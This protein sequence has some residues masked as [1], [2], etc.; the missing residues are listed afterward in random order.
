MNID[1]IKKELEGD[2]L[3]NNYKN[4]YELYNYIIKI[5]RFI[6]KNDVV[7][8]N[9]KYQDKIKSFKRT[10]NEPKKEE[11]RSENKSDFSIY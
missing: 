1:A 10:I 4:F 11:I 2:I 7:R 8:Y 5:W 3:A 9:K 6:H